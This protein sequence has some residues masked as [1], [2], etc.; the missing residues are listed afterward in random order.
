MVRAA[1]ELSRLALLRDGATIHHRDPVGDMRDHP[2]IVRDEQIGQAELRP[3]IGEQVQ[4][5]GLNGHI[6]RRDRL[7]ADGESRPP[8]KATCNADALLLP[9]RHL[10]R[11]ARAIA[12]RQ[13]DQIQQ[14]VDHRARCDPLGDPEQF[15]RTLRPALGR[16][17]VW[18]SS[19][20]DRLQSSERRAVASQPG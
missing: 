11:I 1:Q 8:R 17:R 15:E 16:L 20:A 14:P 4:H 2:D 6:E 9:A 13:P 5:G 19:S 7:V 12:A 3:Q 10:V 18:Q